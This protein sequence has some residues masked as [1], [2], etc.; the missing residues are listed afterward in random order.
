[1]LS[2]LESDHK[3]WMSL[4]EINKKAREYLWSVNWSVIFLEFVDYWLKKKFLS[5]EEFMKW[6]YV[7]NLKKAKKIL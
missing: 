5:Y 4:E 2:I 3:H 7:Q 6:C 1:M